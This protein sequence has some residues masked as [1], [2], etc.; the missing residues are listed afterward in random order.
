VQD[1]VIQDVPTVLKVSEIRKEM[2][3]EEGK[4]G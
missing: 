3:R 4:G 2:E 1:I